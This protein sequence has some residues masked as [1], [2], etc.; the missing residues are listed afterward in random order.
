MKNQNVSRRGFMKALSIAGVGSAV[1]ARAIAQSEPQPANAA[2]A[3]ARATVGTRVFGKTGEKVSLLSLGGIFDITTNQLVL[4]RA[5]D[6]GVTYWDTANSY[7]NGNS[8]KGI[9]MYFEKN[10]DVRKKI[11]LVTKAG[12]PHNAEHL[13]AK[14]AESLQRLKT[15]Y[16]DLFFLHGIRNGDELTPE[17]KAWAEK[18]K[19]AKKIR[20]FG[21]STHGNMES[22]LQ[23]AAKLGW[24]DGIM[25]K[26]DY[27][28][29][30][31]D[32]MRSA[33]DAC[34]KAGI[35]LTAMKTQG[36]GP[37][38]VETEADLKLGGHFVKRGFTEHQAKLKAVWENPQ[39]AAIC[40]QM[41][42]IAFLTANVAAS[43][44]KTK[45]TAADHS[46][47]REYATETCTRYC[48]GCTEICESALGRQLPIADVMRSLMYRHT[49]GD[50]ILARETLA[51]LPEAIRANM[52]T[53]DFAAAERVCPNRLPIAQLMQEASKWIA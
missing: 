44:D 38:K 28:L 2:P 24:I 11:F 33:M 36:G 31:T 52:A 48:D 32:A 34:E 1:G 17:M 18:A 6:F 39:I 7:T 22:S 27:R 40:S 15:D 16:V 26:Y 8:E 30:Q 5:L 51:Q 10:P 3:A 21:F 12:G 29:M 45:L 42:N 9:G 19:A 14:L 23:S 46:A 43:L 50:E 47:L 20:F 41:P 4:R 25:L 35:G 53:F 49:Y 37:I 13:D